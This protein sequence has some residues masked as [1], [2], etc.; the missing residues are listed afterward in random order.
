MRYENAL[1][2]R[3][4]AHISEQ[5]DGY[6]HHANTAQMASLVRRLVESP[7]A[8]IAVLEGPAS[9][10]KSAFLAEALKAEGAK[11]LWVGAHDFAA[12]GHQEVGKLMRRAVRLSFR[13]NLKVIEGEIVAMSASKLTLKTVDMESVFDIGHRIGAELEKERAGVGSVVRI[14][15]ESGFVTKLG[16]SAATRA[17]QEVSFVPVVELPEGECIKTETVSTDLSLDEL[18]V[19]N[20]KEEAEELLYRR[21]HVSP[22]VQAEVDRKVRTW[23]TEDKATVS[24]G[25]LVI[26]DADALA[27]PLLGLIADYK[28]A[29]FAP[30]V[31]LLCEKA[32][33]LLKDKAFVLR[34]EAP[35]PAALASI[36]AARARFLRIELS[37]EAGEMLGALAQQHGL[38]HAM[39]IM[40]LSTEAGRLSTELIAK[41]SGLFRAAQ[42]VNKCE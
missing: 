36:F 1:R 19:I 39:Q 11:P 17:A 3:S 16:R 5:E 14:Y 20:Y 35:T 40:Y 42:S 31:V 12:G 26:H 8:A 25:V 21:V 13:E 7:K 30:L 28:N 10:C 34:I 15:K 38:S 23:V 24:K 6:V 32:P 41:S 18:D 27:A 9:A 4:H 2:L 29:E 22:G 37:D 33:Q